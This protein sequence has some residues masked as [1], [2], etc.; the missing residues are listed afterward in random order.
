MYA[1]RPELGSGQ[2]S[3]LSRGQTVVMQTCW[4]PLV[5]YADAM[6]LAMVLSSHEVDRIASE[7]LSSF[8]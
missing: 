3:S 4:K 8:C 7:L 1:P 6:F 2:L 5:F